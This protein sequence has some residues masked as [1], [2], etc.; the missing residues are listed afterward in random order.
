MHIYL[1][2]SSIAFCTLHLLNLPFTFPEGGAREGQAMPLRFRSRI[3]GLGEKKLEPYVNLC[4]VC[5]EVLVIPCYVGLGLF[6]PPLPSPTIGRQAGFG[7]P[8]FLFPP[9][10][11]RDS[12][13]TGCM[14]SLLITKFD[15]YIILCFILFFPSAISLVHTIASRNSNRKQA[16]GCDSD[17][18]KPLTNCDKKFRFLSFPAN[19]STKSRHLWNH[20][21]WSCH[22]K[23]ERRNPCPNDKSCGVPGTIR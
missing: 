1:Y 20:S 9:L 13:V 4:P 18:K 12:A 10:L 8:F 6:F 15:G 17:F 16:L 11:L 22:D 21:W 3:V 7:S 5:N 23:A 14:R 19:A 2:I